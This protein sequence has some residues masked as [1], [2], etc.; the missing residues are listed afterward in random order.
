MRP[1]FLLCP[2]IFPVLVFYQHVVDIVGRKMDI[3]TQLQDGH[4]TALNSRHL[5]EVMA[6]SN[7]RTNVTVS[8]E[9]MEPS[10]QIFDCT[11]IELINVHE[12]MGDGVY[13]QKFHAESGGKPLIVKMVTPDTKE[14]KMCL[15]LIGPKLKVTDLKSRC[16]GYGEYS[17]IQEILLLHQMLHPGFARLLGYCLRNSVHFDGD[18]TRQGL[19]SVYEDGKTVTGQH[20]ISTPWSTRLRQALELAKLTRHLRD[21]PLGSLLI[22]ELDLDNFIIVDSNIKLID[23]DNVVSYDTVCS[24]SSDC[25]FQLPCVDGQCR[26][27][28]AIANLRRMRDIFF[29]KLLLPNSFPDIIKSRVARV[30]Q[31]LNTISIT[32]DELVT[33]LQN[34]RDTAYQK[35]MEYLEMK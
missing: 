24:D 7:S 18:M 20:L 10:L 17:L 4:N 28:N 1:K 29:N 9:H 30:Y 22:P 6:N 3:H 35:I 19:V 21:S 12:K 33:E 5:L 25:D 15:D 8:S 11:N 13:K 26:G 14:I 23:M 2:L 31:R 16:F 27:Y 32:T 34:I